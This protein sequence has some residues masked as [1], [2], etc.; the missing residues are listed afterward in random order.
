MTR[1]IASKISDIEY[2]ALVKIVRGE[3][4]NVSAFIRDL[5]V[6]KLHEDERTSLLQSSEQIEKKSP[7]QTEQ[8]RLAN[9]LARQFYR[10]I[11]S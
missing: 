11:H 9:Q 1:M 2:E 8:Q 3:G 5:I 4:S 6:A 7:E 10:Y